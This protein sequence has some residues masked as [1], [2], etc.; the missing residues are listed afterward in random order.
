MHMRRVMFCLFLAVGMQAQERFVPL[1]VLHWND[2]HARNV[3]YS[4]TVKDSVAQRDTTYRIGGTATLLGYINK[5]RA[6]SERVLVLNGGDDFQG[7]PISAITKGRSQIDLMNIIQPDAMV[8]GNHE[9]DYG[10][11]SLL[12]HLSHATFPVVSSNL[13]DKSRAKQY[14]PPAIVR[15]FKEMNVGILGLSPPDLESLVVRDS[16]RDI[17]MLP[18][19]SVVVIALAQF[20]KDSVDLIVVLSHMGSNNDER[21]AKRFPS[22]DVIVGGHDHRPIRTPLRVG[23]TLIV[24]AGSYGRYLGKLDLV[25]DTRGDSVFCYNGQLIEMRVSDITP[26]P[27]VLKK[28]EELENR[29][30]K[31]MREVIGELATPWT[32]AGYGKRAESNIG[33]WQADVIRSY[34]KSDAAF[35]NAGGIRDNLKAGPITVGDMWRI[36]PFGNTFVQLSISG[37][38]LR[39]MI[40]NHLAG[41]LDEK[42]H[43]SGL[44]IVFDS[45]KPK[46]NKLL[47]ISI[48]NQPLDDNRTYTFATNNYV[49]SNLMTHFGAASDKFEYTYFPDLDR[50]VFI[51]QIRKEKR[52]SSTVDGRMRDVATEK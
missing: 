19:D 11:R 36:A 52:I 8:L 40:E 7:S 39:E 3:P 32:T 10:S 6:T 24:Q 28:V 5:F 4:V 23:R 9:F 25:V 12:E 41:R 16:I 38:V 34:T 44:R 37:V 18:I 1:T 14:V 31:E 30:G 2:F 43:F 20:K 26:D 48:G 22:L 27:I 35:Q 13:W 46:G 42:G 29:T 15:R 50:D 33:N 49:V 47:E 51:A 21:L 17:Q 45:R